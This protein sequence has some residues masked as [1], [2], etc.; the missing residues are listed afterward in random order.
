MLHRSFHRQPPAVLSA[1]VFCHPQRL[2]VLS[3]S[4]SSCSIAVRQQSCNIQP[5]RHHQSLFASDAA[6]SNPL[7]FMVKM[8]GHLDSRSKTMTQWEQ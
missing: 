8:N 2:G 6:S 7:R 3:F 4:T 5:L 1:L